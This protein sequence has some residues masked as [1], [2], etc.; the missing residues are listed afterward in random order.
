MIK[1]T[2]GIQKELFDLLK[3][4]DWQTMI[5]LGN[6]TCNKIPFKKMFEEQGIKHTSIDFNGK[7]GALALNLAHPIDLPSADIVTNYG[8]SEHILK[9]QEQVFRNIHNFSH[10]RIIHAVPRIGNF[11]HHGFWHF[12]VDFFKL[13]A[14]LNNYK[15]DKLFYLNKKPRELVC[16]SYTKINADEFKWENSLP[17]EYNITTKCPYE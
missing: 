15:I 6:K 4:F 10:H 12:E 13:L 7:D 9:N 3:P 1:N 5:E 2:L 14:E 8:T 11:P 17:M 16:C